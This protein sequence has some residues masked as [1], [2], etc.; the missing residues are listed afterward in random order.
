MREVPPEFIPITARSLHIIGAEDP[1]IEHSRLLVT[2]FSPETS[3]VLSHAE[4]HNIPSLRTG[5]Y[6]LL[7]TFHESY[8][9]HHQCSY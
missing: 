9:Q 1:F 6:V 7:C 2:F 5:A 4:G 8:E 3:L